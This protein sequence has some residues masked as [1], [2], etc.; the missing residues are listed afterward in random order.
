MVFSE[1]IGINALGAGYY[2]GKEF[3]N[4]P[5]YVKRAILSTATTWL[6]AYY[7]HI[8]KNTKNFHKSVSDY[9]E[10]TLI[11]PVHSTLVNGQIVKDSDKADNVE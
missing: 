9:Y 11:T 5:Y 2:L 10:K 7:T 6:L 4:S 8:E 3:L 1:I